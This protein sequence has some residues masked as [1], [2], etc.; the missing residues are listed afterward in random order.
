MSREKSTEC[1]VNQSNQPNVHSADLKEKLVHS[2]GHCLNAKTID[3]LCGVF[4]KSTRG[5]C[6]SCTLSSADL[7]IYVVGVLCDSISNKVNENQAKLVVALTS[8]LIHLILLRILSQAMADMILCLITLLGRKLP[9]TKRATD[10][11]D[12]DFDESKDGAKEVIEKEVIES[13]MTNLGASI[14]SLHTPMI[15]QDLSKL[16]SV[17]KTKSET[18][19]PGDGDVFI[20]KAVVPPTP[21]ASGSPAHNKAISNVISVD[22]YDRQPGMDSVKIPPEVECVGEA[23]LSDMRS[24]LPV[25]IDKLYNA[26]YLKC[27]TSY[28]GPSNIEMIANMPS[29]TA[30]NIFQTMLGTI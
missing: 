29:Y 22:E 5:N 16:S 30:A 27:H 11:L 25:N 28:H 4:S 12:H 23:K 10:T 21:A 13:V 24:Q 1:V 18:C 8:L 2:F 9:Q 14:A 3:G 6:S 19:P 15:V 17:V 26:K 20:T 7:V